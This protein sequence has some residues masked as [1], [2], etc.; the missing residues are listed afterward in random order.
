M[1]CPGPRN[2]DGVKAAIIVAFSYFIVPTDL[3]PDVIIGL[4]YTDDI[5]VSLAA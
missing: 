2:A 4:G 3:I 1:L 5:T